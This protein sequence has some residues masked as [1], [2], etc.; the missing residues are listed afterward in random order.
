MGEKMRSR[1]TADYKIILTIT[2][3]HAEMTTSQEKPYSQTGDNYVVLLKNRQKYRFDFV[4]AWLSNRDTTSARRA[5]CRRIWKRLPQSVNRNLLGIWILWTVQRFLF[6]EWILCG[7]TGSLC[8][9]DSDWSGNTMNHCRL[10]QNSIV[11]YRLFQ[12]LS[13]VFIVSCSYNALLWKSSQGN[14]LPFISFV[15]ML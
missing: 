8:G 9:M 7:R 12:W 15:R 11:S 3:A 4:L 5:I 6:P 2:W 1:L 13:S 14:C 10:S